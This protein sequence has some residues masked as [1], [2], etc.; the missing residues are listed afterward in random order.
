[1]S[2]PH[3]ICHP[4][5]P[6]GLPTSASGTGSQFQ[7]LE[8]AQRQGTLNSGPEPSEVLEDTSRPSTAVS[9][10]PL[11]EESHERGTRVWEE[12]GELGR[13]DGVSGGSPES[14]SGWRQF[15]RQDPRPAPQHSGDT[16]TTAQASGG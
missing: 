10:R 15:C 4:R 8:R 16:R 12:D 3:D 5:V 11:E 14:L 7:S 1:M 2:H 13:D 9:T 6:R